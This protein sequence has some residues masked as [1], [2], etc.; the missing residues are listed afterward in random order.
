MAKVLTIWRKIIYRD[1]FVYVCDIVIKLER[2]LQDAKVLTAKL[3]A[4]STVWIV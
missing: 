4:R 1:V 3:V 2:K